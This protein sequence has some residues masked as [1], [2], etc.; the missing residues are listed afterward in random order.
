MGTRWAQKTV[1]GLLLML[2]TLTAPRAQADAPRVVVIGVG[3]NNG[4]DNEYPLRFAVQDAERFGQVMAELGDVKH[5]DL[6]L[7]ANATKAQFLQELARVREQS[8]PDGTL[9]VYFSGHGSTLA[10][11]LAGEKLN[12]SELHAAINAVPARFRLLLVDACRGEARKGFQSGAEPF[13]VGMGSPGGLVAIHS[14]G[15]GEIAVESN[16]LKAGVFSHLFVSGL[17]GPAD[18]NHDYA[19]SVGE[20]YDYAKAHQVDW[21]SP[22]PEMDDASAS[23]ATVTLTYLR[24][25][26]HRAGPMLGPRRG[27]RLWRSGGWAPCGVHR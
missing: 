7:L 27:A 10:L 3:S 16:E 2:V 19:V 6:H 11:H 5:D 20:A 17:R 8:G 14:T 15:L 9:V 12:V 1:L 21:G 18:A 4:L 22:S 26:R 23:T 25:A 24:P 13:E